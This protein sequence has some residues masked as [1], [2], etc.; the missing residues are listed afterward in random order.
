YFPLPPCASPLHSTWHRSAHLTP[1]PTSPHPPP[2]LRNPRPTSPSQKIKVYRA[3]PTP[4]HPREWSQQGTSIARH[5]APRRKRPAPPT[6]TSNYTVTV[7]WSKASI[8]KEM[9]S[10]AVSFVASDIIKIFDGIQA[11]RGARRGCGCGVV[12]VRHVGCLVPAA[13]YYAWE[14]FF[15]KTIST[16]PAV[17]IAWSGAIYSVPSA[18]LGGHWVPPR[19]E[20]PGVQ[21]RKRELAIQSRVAFIKTI[22]IMMVFG[23]LPATALVIFSA[24]SLNVSRI[25]S[26]LTFPILSLFNILRFPLVVL[27]KAM[28]AASDMLASNDR[29]ARSHSS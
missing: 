20:L 16:R 11:R 28:R 24:S 25:T 27:P 13:R 21:I 5:G 10:D 26:T 3:H 18:V 8:T 2:S 29:R 17:A 15:E 22:Q 1:P 6:T 14:Q 9:A 12:G 23:T 7:T 4:P 19:A